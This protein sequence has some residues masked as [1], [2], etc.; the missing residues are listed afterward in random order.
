MATNPRYANGHRRRE[1]TA[2][3][4]A[5]PVPCDW[6][7]CPWPTDLLGHQVRATIKAMR[8]DD[9]WLDDRYPVVD[10]I[11]PVS[12]GGSVTARDNTRLLHRWCNQE[13]GA[14]RDPGKPRPTITSSPGWGPRE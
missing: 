3:L 2:R 12:H 13:R 7:A 14:G 5:S 8:P 4:L 11:V 10:E 9:Y 6:P 1:L